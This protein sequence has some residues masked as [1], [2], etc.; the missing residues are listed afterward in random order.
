MKW[1][2]KTYLR[3]GVISFIILGIGH[4]FG[5]VQMSSDGSIEKHLDQYD[6]KLLGSTF[7]LYQFH[8]GYSVMMGLLI[9]FI[10]LLLL[11]LQE[12]QKQTLF[13]LAIGSIII[14]GLIWYFFALPGQIF[15]TI[16]AVFFSLAY[17]KFP[18]VE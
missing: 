15:S 14:C 17:W 5:E 4:L 18:K 1:T 2:Y 7:S 10:G 6:F 13:L 9:I 12:I 3:I 8:L 16:S 11:T